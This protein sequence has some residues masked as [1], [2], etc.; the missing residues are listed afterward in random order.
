MTAVTRAALRLVRQERE[1]P[2]LAGEGAST[3]TVQ[4]FQQAGARGYR[5]AEL[6]SLRS[7]N[8]P[9]TATREGGFGP[10]G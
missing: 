7:P 5:R 4:N 8:P 1:L 3:D 9:D 6:Y 10:C 2:G